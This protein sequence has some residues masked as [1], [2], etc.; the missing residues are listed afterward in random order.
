MVMTSLLSK[1]EVPKYYMGKNFENTDISGLPQII[2]T[3]SL[4]KFSLVD[5]RLLD[6]YN[7]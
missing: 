2:V 4:G 7:N 3:C 1:V 6:K 5:N